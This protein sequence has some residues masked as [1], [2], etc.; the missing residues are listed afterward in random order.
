[1]SCALNVVRAYELLKGIERPNEMSPLY[2]QPELDTTPPSL[3]VV[4]RLP[5]TVR[6]EPHRALVLLLTWNVRT[7]ESRTMV[8]NT[9]V[10]LL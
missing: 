6:T 10:S 8:D 9:S 3:S 4:P 1:M 2:G 5:S 7:C